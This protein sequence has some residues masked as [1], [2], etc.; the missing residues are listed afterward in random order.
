MDTPLV[1]NV[2]VEAMEEGKDTN[3]TV[4]GVWRSRM[5]GLWLFEYKKRPVDCVLTS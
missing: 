5:D 2:R 3:K 4:S 1:K